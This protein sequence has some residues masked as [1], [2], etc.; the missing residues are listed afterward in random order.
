MPAVPPD[1]P[2]AICRVLAAGCTWLAL[3]NCGWA[4]EPALASTNAS[5]PE[6]IGQL[7]EQLGDESFG[8]RERATEQLV[9]IGVAARPELTAALDDSDAEVRFRARR[10]LALVTASDFDQRL[11]AFAADVDDVRHLNLPGWSA[12]QH[13]IGADA[14][15][16]ALFVEMQLSEGA[17]LEAWAESPKRSA[18]ALADRARI[19]YEQSRPRQVRN[20]E[21]TVANMGSVAALL[22]IAGDASVLLTD[23]VAAR[24]VELPMNP[25]IERAM[26]IDPQ[27]RREAL[28]KLLGRWVVREVSPPL[29]TR[30]LNAAVNYSLREG[31]TPAERTLRK[32][33]MPA[34]AK[35]SALILLA[36]FGGKDHLPLVE[37]LFDDTD[38]CANFGGFNRQIQTQIRDV[39]LTTAI[40]LQ[41]QDPKNFGLGQLQSDGQGWYQLNS[42]GFAV[43]AERDAAQAKW[44]SWKKMQKQAL[45][46]KRGI[47][48]AAQ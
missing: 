24:L 42:I 32:P 30:S 35:C 19:L 28:R 20:R 38:P 47:H 39:A 13:S 5:S 44:E 21:P 41:G 9:L 27:P 25:T 6:A 18:V 40:Q 46:T 31:L 34:D 7:V 16:R 14:A 45:A 26:A 23:P 15:S 10:I 2:N 17:L 29:A 37:S 43:D 36:K 8:V 11:K 1:S 3:A 22:W 12:F 48:S 4:E 33:N